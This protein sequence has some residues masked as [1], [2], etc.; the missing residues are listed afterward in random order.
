M[1]GVFVLAST[2]MSGPTA[3]RLRRAEDAKAV[4]GWTS[5]GLLAQLESGRF[6]CSQ[7]LVLC[8]GGCRTRAADSGHGTVPTRVTGYMFMRHCDCGVMAV[9]PGSDWEGR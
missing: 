4:E 9:Y 6:F 8:E 3:R 5:V 7:S 1:L 2:G